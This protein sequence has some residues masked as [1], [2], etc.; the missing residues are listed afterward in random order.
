[1]QTTKSNDGTTIGYETNG[2]GEPLVLLHG[3]TAARD[4]WRPFLPHL[5]DAGQ[6]VAVDRRGRASSG[7]AK[8]YDLECE[9]DDVQCVLEDVGASRLFGHSFGGLCALNAAERGAVDLEKLILYE[10]AVLVGDHRE[11]DVGARM[12]DL[13]TGGDREGALRL[14][15]ER[16]GIEDV[17]AL[18]HWPEVLELAEVTQREFA[19]VDAYELPESLD[20]A[21]ETLVLT[22]ERSPTFLQD[23]ARE[24]Y[25]RLPNAELVEI[26]GAGHAGVENP[27]A[28]AAPVAEFLQ[29]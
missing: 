14:A 5:G 25:R 18:P 28:V 12:A 27:P 13:I 20:V 24:V 1:M 29:G 8:A 21:A 7:N 19:A 9:V 4:H 3:S 16:V 22:G 26:E 15:F 17:E 10:P 2:D 11:Y 23:G 6:F